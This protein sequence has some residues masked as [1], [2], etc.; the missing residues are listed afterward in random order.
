MAAAPITKSEANTLDNTQQSLQDASPPPTEI[1]N[2]NSNSNNNKSASGKPAK[3]QA[4]CLNPHPCPV[5]AR[6]YSNVS[7]LRQHMR[8]IHNR[9]EVCCPLCQK[10]FNSQLY[11]KRHYTS[12]HGYPNGTLSVSGGS[13]GGSG[14]VGVV[15]GMKV[16]EGGSNSNNNNKGSN[17]GAGGAGSAHGNSGWNLYEMDNS[18]SGNM[19]Q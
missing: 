16:E 13:D 6:L 8:L 15:P 7:N 19:C 17:G 12:V 1:H 10:N 5:C 2:N 14:V 3:K 4:N 18:S 9:T 11:L